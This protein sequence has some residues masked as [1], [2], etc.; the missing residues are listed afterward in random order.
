MRFKT[1]LSFAIKSIFSE[2]Y[3][4]VQSI[5]FATRS[6]VSNRYMFL[7]YS[8]LYHFLSEVIT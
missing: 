2:R 3:E 7:K 6:T 1:V 8:R 4:V 5:G